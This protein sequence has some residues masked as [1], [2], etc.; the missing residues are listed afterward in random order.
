MK[1]LL[2]AC[3][4]LVGCAGRIPLPQNLKAANAGE[5]AQRMQKAASSVRAYSAEARLAYF[6]KEGRMRGTATLVVSRP[7]SLR[8]DVYGPHG[9]VVSA[10]ATNGQELALLDVAQS[11]YLY[12]PATSRNLDELLPFA[13]LGLGADG[14]VA[15]LFGEVTVPQDAGLSYDDRAGHFVLEWLSGGLTQR[16]E[17]DPKT[18]RPVRARVLRGDDVVSEVTL[19]ERDKKGIPT[20]L[21]IKV[22]KQ[23]VDVDVAL[24]DLSYEPELDEDVFVLSP[25]TGV[26]PERL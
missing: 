9:G 2:L 20:A 11:R 1:N 6:G 12:G 3:S 21:R 13:P 25:P 7:A 8:Y 19:D 23:D 22:P 4:I 17:V 10:F 14:W 16:L 18:S 24:K 26:N 15:L 5:L